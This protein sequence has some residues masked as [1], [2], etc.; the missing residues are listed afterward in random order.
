MLHFTMNMPLYL[1][2]VS[3]SILLLMVLVLRFLLKK[4]LPGYVFPIL[5]SLVLIR[6]LVPFSLSSPLSLKVSSLP[7]PFLSSTSDIETSAGRLAFE[8]K[9]FDSATED[10]ADP[11]AILTRTPDTA[12]HTG[13][14]EDIAP[15]SEA[16][17]VPEA[18]IEAGEASTVLSVAED[19]SIPDAYYY[20][21]AE[22]P[23]SISYQI[24]E[25]PPSLYENDFTKGLTTAVYLLGILVTAGI[26]L[27]QK[28][29]YYG[30]LKNSLLIEHNET[31]NAMLRKMKMGHVL[32][33]TNDAIASPLV[34]GLLMPRIYLPTRM[35]FQNRHLLHHILAHETM[36][37]RHRDNWIK[38]VM[39]IVLCLN[40]FNPLVWLMAICLASDLETACDEAVLRTCQDE[41]SRK[42]YAFSLLAMAVTANRSPLLYSAFS[43]TEVEKR[44]QRILHY[45][46]TSALMLSAVVLLLASGSVAFATGIQAPFDTY[47]SSTCYY[48]S[49]DSHW[50]FKVYLTRDIVLGE[51]P[52]KRADDTILAVLEAD[53]TGDPDLIKERIK[54]ALAEEFHVE[55]GTFDPAASFCIDE[56]TEAQEYAAWELTRDDNGIFCYQGR[57]VHS[58]TD[59]LNRTYQSGMDGTLDIL[60]QRN[61]LGHI[62]SVT[63][64]QDGVIVRMTSAPV[65]EEH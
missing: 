30:K 36:H 47:L 15:A 58:F 27:F 43:K 34:C 13:N 42:S 28:Y 22:T 37:I 29:R 46:K 7:V 2:M 24:S 55:K 19:S 21:I 4:K 48:G 44:I 20:R 11:D 35:D 16:G 52:G 51:N 39:L 23:L 12:A 25:V 40:W 26:L 17:T 10:T 59:E 62:S 1:M 49:S 18:A 33:F 38:A 6:F 32:V 57:T 53:T 61:R 54:E 45:K 31:I 60:V 50:A 64:L 9:F 5:W 65:E 41:E 3:G 14:T 56:E 63:A 8:E